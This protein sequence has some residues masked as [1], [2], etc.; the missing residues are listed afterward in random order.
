MRHLHD[1]ER[2]A[3][4]RWLPVVVV[5]ALLAAGAG[6]YF[7]AWDRFQD[8]R[9]PDPL[10]EPE[11]VPPPEGLELPAY[12]DPPAVVPGVATG[13]GAQ[14]DPAAVRAA[15]ARG[16]RDKALG[17]H[18]IVSVGDLS[19]SGPDWTSGS[20]T[21]APA[22]TTKI[23]T[24]VAALEALG[25]DHTFTTRVVEGESPRRL[26]LVGGGDPYL[27]SKPVPADEQD[28]TYPERADV[29]TLAREVAERRRGQQ[30]RGPVRL[31]YDASLFTGPTESARWEPDYIPDGIVSPITSLWVDQGRD[32]SGLGRV[33]DPAR[34]AAQVFSRALAREGVRVQGRPTPGRALPDSA[35]VAA[36]ESAPLGDIVEHVLDVSDNESAEVL[37]HHVGLSESNSG[38]FEAGARDTT[39]VL[40]RLGVPVQGLRLFDGSGLS[41]A[42]RIGSSTMLGALRVAAET[43]QD[44]LRPLITGLPV[45]GFTGSLT[46]RFADGP[47]VG[48]GAVR[49]KTGTLTGVHSLA[50]VTT[51]RTGATMVFVLAADKVKVADTLAAREALDRLAAALAACRCAAAD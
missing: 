35:E 50:G 24:S 1:R 32:P 41:R 30:A 20:G 51:D 13:R 44:D 11:S 34:T 33:G 10:T 5:I 42:N 25:P 21:F 27:G 40:R 45:A 29:V 9:R 17:R 7:D 19:G 49:A 26:V 48:R 47:A 12:D 43:G 6:V 36:V 8:W 22:S 28:T 18:V 15:L 14:V 4:S 23:L 39:A 16:L 2:G 38:S 46:Y 37:A 31:T 3:L